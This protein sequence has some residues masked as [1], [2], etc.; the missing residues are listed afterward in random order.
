MN[1]KRKNID[2]YEKSGLEKTLAVV[3]VVTLVLN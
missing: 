1:K 2:I 3:I